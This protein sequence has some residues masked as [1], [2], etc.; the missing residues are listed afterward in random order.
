MLLNS[1]IIGSTNNNI[2]IAHGL[3]GN[4]DS[5]LNI[6]KLLAEN[7]TIHL[8]DLRN[9]GKS[10]HHKEMNYK[11]MV[12]DILEYS[13]THN[14]DAFHFI[15][16]SMGGKLAIHFANLYPSR[17]KK[18]IVADISPKSY[19]SLTE[20]NEIINSHLN[21]ISFIKNFDLDKYKAR[22]EILEQLS[23][24]PDTTKSIIL[25][26]IEKKVGGLKWR[27]NIDSIFNNLDLIMSGLDIDDFINKKIETKALFLKA[28][29][30]NYIDTNDEKIIKFIFPNS[31]IR[32][33][34]NA[35][36][37]LQIEQAEQV[38]LEIIKFIEK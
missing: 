38:A 24:F 32:T 28:E 6:A 35:S 14:L 9:H 12:N 25:K 29:N 31:E 34:L 1:K 10:F 30:S 19:V 8:L 33:I 15:G 37:W 23:D 4:C 7:Y 16:H 36:H 13:S 5:W 20:K 21:L 27:I 17:L 11:E 18:I 2:L 26:N 22:G 3:Y